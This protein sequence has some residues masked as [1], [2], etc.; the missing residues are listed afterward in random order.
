MVVRAISK[1]IR[2]SPFKI[3]PYTDVIKGYSVDKAYAWLKTCSVKRVRP[4]VKTL[5]SAYSNGKNKETGN[6]SMSDF[7]I[8]EIKVN[9]G[10]MIKYF[11]PAAQGRASVQ[12]KRMSH[13]EIVLEKDKK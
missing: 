8:K 10:P 1:Y 12:R 2:I 7:R 4:I 11:K 13:I 3:R 5:V 9:Q 6:L